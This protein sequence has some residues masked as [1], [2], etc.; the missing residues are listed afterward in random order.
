VMD[1]ASRNLPFS[2]T[3]DRAPLSGEEVGDGSSTSDDYQLS[4]RVVLQRVCEMW[5]CPQKSLRCVDTLGQPSLRLHPLPESC[6][7]LRHALVQR[8]V[9]GSPA[10]VAVVAPRIA[11]M[12]TSRWCRAGAWRALRK[13]TVSLV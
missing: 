13:H 12:A 4:A 10:G 9:F 6:P 7:V 8:R 1:T 5:A 2:S 3:I 11:Q